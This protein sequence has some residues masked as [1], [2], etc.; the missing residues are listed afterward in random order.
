MKKNIIRAG[1]KPGDTVVVTGAARGFGQAIAQRLERY[2]A[3]LALWDVIEEE[4]NLAAT[5]CRE[6]GAETAFL[7]CDMGN[8]DDIK[9]AA[10]SVLDQFS[11]VYAVVNNASNKPFF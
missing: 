6:A 7:N 3:K 9:T 5:I 4:G 10:E 8:P 2:G 1:L 11:S